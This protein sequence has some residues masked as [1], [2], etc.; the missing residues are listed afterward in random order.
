VEKIIVVA[1]IRGEGEHPWRFARPT[2]D[3]RTGGRGKFLFLS[4]SLPVLQQ[5]R[6]EYHMA[7]GSTEIPARLLLLLD[8][9]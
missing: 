6:V 2:P 7:N 1:E 8:S 4:L 3:H 9:A 5:F